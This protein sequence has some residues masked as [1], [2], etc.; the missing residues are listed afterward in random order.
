M[1][2]VE[3]NQLDAS[4]NIMFSLMDS[5]FT[6]DAESIRKML[7]NIE[8]ILGEVCNEQTRHLFQLKH[9]PKYADLLA[10][11]L[12]Q[13]TK[14]VSKIRDTKEVLK[15]RSLELKRQRVDLNPVL[16]ELI[17]Q[18]KKLQLHIENDISKRYKNRV[19]NLMG[20][21]N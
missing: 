16:A 5:I 12:R 6:Y 8:L 7:R 1:R 11:K 9:S 14:A 3:L 2:L 18:T 21:V 4:S 17:S 13:M 10:T 15:I 20:G 19:V